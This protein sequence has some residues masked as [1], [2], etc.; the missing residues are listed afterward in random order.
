MPVRLVSRLTT[1]LAF[2]NM[3]LSLR[4]VPGRFETSIVAQALFRCALPELIGADGPALPAG[5]PLIGS[6]SSVARSFERSPETIRRHVQVLVGQGFFT[7]ERDGVRLAPTAEAGGRVLAYL[8]CV[9]DNMLWLVEELDS[10]GLVKCRAR[11]EQGAIPVKPILRAA[12]DLLLFGFEGFRGPLGGWTSLAV[13]NALSAASVRHVTLSRQLSS[14]FSQRSTPDSLRRPISLRALCAASGLPHATVWRHLAALEASGRV[15]RKGD[16]YVVL[17]GQLL[18]GDMEARVAHY[19]QP[20]LDR[21][22]TL[23]ARGLDPAAIPSLY[24]GGR[25]APVPV[26]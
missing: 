21:V 6:I 26:R 7:V 1:E 22:N 19:V 25:P 5:T 24:I 16:G 4:L 11:K 2:M 12:M 18:T 3:N 17:T 23:V 8:R 14:R 9:N 13:W 15:G 10:W 20:T